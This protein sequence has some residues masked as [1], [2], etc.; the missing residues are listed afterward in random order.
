[1]QV[2]L[3]GKNKTIEIPDGTSPQEMEKIAKSY[4]TPDELY[5]S[6][7]FA[8]RE[9]YRARKG[10][11]T[12]DGGK[13]MWKFMNGELSKE[14]AYSIYDESTKEFTEENDEKYA[15]RFF[16]EKLI[17]A[18]TEL[19]P[20][21]LDSAMEGAKYGET[22][23]AAAAT[24]ALIGGQAGPQAAL[25]EE[26][27]TV[28]TAYF[29]G[30]AVGQAYGSWMNA[31]QVEGGMVFKE[32]LDNGVDPE[33]AKNWA[34]PAGYL[35]GA[36]EMM[37]IKTLI[38]GFGK[39][40]RKGLTEII[41]SAAKKKSGNL[42]KRM[43]VFALRL[44]K[45]M[46]AFMATE[47]PEEVIQENISI[48]AE[49][50][51]AI[52]D[53]EAQHE[54]YS[55]P[56]NEEIK[57]RNMDT[58]INSLMAFPLLGLPGSVHTTM[59]SYGRERA[60][61][62]VIT[63]RAAKALEQDLG[64]LI[65]EATQYKTYAEYMESLDEKIDD[66]F[67]NSFGFDNRATFT[68]AIWNA[69]R[70]AM[71]EEKTIKKLAA[72]KEAGLPSEEF[73]NA[74]DRATELAE[75]LGV[76]IDNI[77]YVDEEMI[78]DPSDPMDMQI[79]FEHGYT[80]QGVEDAI[81][82]GERFIITGEYKTEGETSEQRRTSVRF[83]RGA[84]DQDAYHEIVVHG[85]ED[86]GGLPGWSGTPEEHAAYLEGIIARGEEGKIIELTEDGRRIDRDVK[87]ILGTVHQSVRLANGPVVVEAGEGT[88]IVEPSSLFDKLLDRDP[89]RVNKEINV[90]KT[91]GDVVDLGAV[92]S[93]EGVEGWTQ[94]KDG[95]GRNKEGKTY[96]AWYADEMSKRMREG[97][98]EVTLDENGDYYFTSP[99][100]PAYKYR[101]ALLVDNIKVKA[102]L[103]DMPA[104]YTCKNCASC[105]PTCYAVGAQV[106]WPGTKLG[107]FANLYMFMNHRETFKNKIN[108]ELA[109]NKRP[110]VRIHTSGDIFSQKYLNFLNE[111]IRDNPNKTFYTYTKIGDLDYS[112]IDQNE[113]FNRVNSVLPTGEK[114]YGDIDYVTKKSKEL[115]I[116]ICPASVAKK[117]TKVFC[118]SDSY[119]G[120]GIKCS[121]CTRETSM[122]FKQHGSAQKGG[123]E[124]MQ[125]DIRDTNFMEKIQHSVRKVSTDMYTKQAKKIIRETTGQTKTED[126]KKDYMNLKRLF[127]R[128][129][130]ETKRVQKEATKQKKEDLK[131]KEAGQKLADDIHYGKKLEKARQKNKAD[132]ERLQKQAKDREKR[133]EAF[134]EKLRAYAYENLKGEDR[135]KMITAIARVKTEAQLDKAMKKVEEIAEMS[136][137]R[138]MIKRIKQ[139]VKRMKAS[140]SIAV[141]YVQKMQDMMSEYNETKPTAKTLARLQATKDF[142]ARE[143]ADGRTTD[144]P[145]KVINA[146]D[147]LNRKPLKDLQLA[148]LIDINEKLRVIADLGK[149]KLRSRK[150]ATE[151]LKQRDL[152]ALQKDSKSIT[153]KKVKQDNAIS[154]RLSGV[155][156]LANGLKKAMN[157]AQ[158]K[159]LMLH[160]MDA[161][162]DLLDG[163]KEYTGANYRIFKRRVDQAFTAYLTM[164]FDI[165][166]R[167]DK[168][169]QD[170]GLDVDSMEK[171]GVYA[172]KMQEGGNEKLLTFFTQ[173]EIDS[174]VLTD[175]EME[176][177]NAMRK[178]LDDLRPKIE[179]VMRE[180]YNKPLGNVAN[181]FPFLTDF[182]AMSDAEVRDRFGGDTITLD[183]TFLKKNVEMGFT[184][185]RVGGKN[186]IKINAAEVF[187]QHIDNAIYLITVGRETKYLGE[188]AK[189]EEY[190]AAVGDV[191]QEV[192]REWVDLLARKGVS[193]GNRLAAVDMAR[194]YTGLVAL[195][196]KLGSTLVQITALMDG[197]ALIGTH[198][199]DGFSKIIKSSA[200][201][202]F[203]LDN[204]PE[205][206]ERIGDD[207][208]FQDFG[209]DAFARKLG[210]MAYMPLKTLDR[211]AATGVAAGAYIKWCKD[212]D[213][214]VDLENPNIEGLEYAEKM[215]RRTQSS[216]QFKDLPMAITKGKLTGN[217][218]VD[219]AILQ[220]QSFMLNRW[221]IVRHDLWR[222]GIRG[223][224]KKQAI[225]IAMWLIAANYMEMGIRRFSKELI[226]GMF[227]QELPEDDEDRA[228]YKTVGQVLSNVP[229][230]GSLFYSTIYGDFPVP[231]VSMTTKILKKFG[232]AIK[233]D[234]D[235]GLKW[236]KALLSATPGGQQI[237]PNIKGE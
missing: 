188:I 86:Q 225:N 175:K 60:V 42:F 46:G 128:I 204:M 230:A 198:A 212:N 172:A 68:E 153:A 56:T 55:G 207:I 97:N 157:V 9:S 210:D 139:Q 138:Q 194:K 76:K 64:N 183:Q 176:F 18:T 169:A 140:K 222:A 217:V 135:G 185:A 37:Q 177:Y 223:K 126:I 80:E 115:G 65:L 180:V 186:K 43:G 108:S 124:A 77:E 205:V 178:E 165:Q 51:A 31:A 57:K 67:A 132:K 8:E 160:P 15:A 16:G 190:A 229:F 150:A 54:G 179:Q 121:M 137:K 162:F 228:F 19:A 117:G 221:S 96:L 49:M 152:L 214:A 59:Q 83:F 88:E 10:R 106:Q 136:A 61:K 219:K 14:Q 104:V 7:S 189:T 209:K 66:K 63:D 159:D 147:I 34:I 26:L 163:G 44:G 166:N 226:A 6:T 20:Y 4:Y 156:K 129:E 113:N 69:S 118:T 111:I 125:Q 50:G 39:M 22:F 199:F 5:G 187:G 164:K 149:T 70:D 234:E 127:Q 17:G 192:V 71:E 235:K 196:F 107:R 184:M 58:L 102:Y 155:E 213:V 142:I 148:D 79:L 200:W 45:N 94:D 145:M 141:D 47:I 62:R 85:L 87:S 73:Q 231:S 11:S 195:G 119:K 109:G 168:K 3:E 23:G 144:I 197:A 236:F 41:K 151:L 100:L 193:Q 114:N 233:A 99:G 36:V 1:M 134:R 215:T 74:I 143:M 202:S 78:L 92:Y 93:M 170:L 52:N 122:L 75:K 237:E 154:G 21:M 89:N 29:M 232:A 110:I 174:V 206:R 208:A 33:I 35:I 201:R 82:N 12:V 167:I 30:K 146:L 95:K 84:T 130:Q 158:M 171:I 216:S 27:I 191:G 218:S 116:K 38:P 2:F 227:G 224:N 120:K 133:L 103:L 28:P 131:W 90:K 98:V 220:F 112:G 182:D 161:I 32:L 211:F 25:P 24:A 181:Y 91:P 13:A 105:A 81:K 101:G 123:A 40:G 48:I 173:K 203:V 53:E 72:E